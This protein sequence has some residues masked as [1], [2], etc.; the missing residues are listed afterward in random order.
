M[1]KFKLT[2]ETQQYFGTTVYRIEA[3]RDIPEWSVKAGDKGGWLEKESNLAQEG[4]CW[5]FDSA[6]VFGEAQVFGG[7]WVSGKAKLSK[8]GHLRCISGLKFHITLTPGYAVI[9]CKRMSIKAWLALTKEQAIGMGLPMGEFELV[10]DALK[11][12]R[13]KKMKTEVCA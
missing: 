13:I 12:L 9:D 11:L 10:R 5:V 2:T 7:A 1:N 6:R 8:P 3:L 4:S